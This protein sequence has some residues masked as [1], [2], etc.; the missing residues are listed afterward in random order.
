[1]DNQFY[2]KFSN[3]SFYVCAFVDKIA[4]NLENRHFDGVMA[5]LYASKDADEKIE[6]STR[7]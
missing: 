5:H 6:R 1:M 4:V 2:G 3:E 7:E